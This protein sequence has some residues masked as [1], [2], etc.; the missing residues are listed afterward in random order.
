MREN[1]L[2]IGVE[3]PT[4]KLCSKCG[5]TV[6]ADSL[7][8]EE[9]GQPLGGAPPEP[10]PNEPA[11]RPYESPPRPP[12][13]ASLLSRLK[14]DKRLLLSVV[15]AA[16]AVVVVILL[17]AAAI[18]PHPP[19]PGLDYSSY[20]NSYYA[21]NGWTLVQPFSMSTNDRGN[22]VYTGIVRNATGGTQQTTVVE[23]TASQADAKNAYDQTVAQK[24]PGFTSRPDWVVNNTAQYPE[25]IEEWAGV[26]QAGTDIRIFY[27]NNAQVS[28]SWEVET[29]IW[30]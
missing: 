27:W 8:C 25:R 21:G 7:F 20:F 6:P 5:A 18:S 26:N 15:G 10:R 28:P 17:V 12:A 2:R 4:E 16:V 23:L 13:S 24:T 9:C 11:A 14:T 29:H 22:T 1:P 30:G 3:M 19:S